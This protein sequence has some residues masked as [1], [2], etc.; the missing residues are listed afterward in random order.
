MAN[1][2]LF[3]TW[4]GRHS[5]RSHLAWSWRMTWRSQYTTQWYYTPPW[6]SFHS[7]I[8][9]AFP[10]RMHCR[11]LIRILW[12]IIFLDDRF[13]KATGGS[14]YFQWD[15]ANTGVVSVS[16]QGE[17]VSNA[18]GSSIVKLTD[19]RNKLH[20]V[21]ADVSSFVSSRETNMHHLIALSGSCQHS[22]ISIISSEID[23]DCSE[24]VTSVAFCHI[25]LGTSQHI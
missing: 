9:R 22:I 25:W 10:S 7:P 5:I 2:W 16:A 14:G 6:L 1:W 12:L 24:Q 17:L 4:K 11:C 23:W 21:M 19:K 20:Y 8:A 13:C 15:S 18:L 3:R